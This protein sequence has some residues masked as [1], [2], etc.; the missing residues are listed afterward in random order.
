[1]TTDEADWGVIPTVCKDI[2]AAKKAAER[3]GSAEIAVRCSFLELYNEEFKDLLEPPAVAKSKNV[4]IREE[5]TEG[6]RQEIVVHG[7]KEEGVKSFDDVAQWI[8]VGCGHRT[9]A[10]TKMNQASSRSHAI[11]TLTIEQQRTIPPT[12][13]S[14]PGEEPETEYITSKFFFVDLAGSE[15]VKKSGTQPFFPETFSEK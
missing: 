13:H 10:A 2:F 3:D 1:M 12:E 15:R 5:L 14:A 7:V 11:F 4:M 8:D 6:G 9:V